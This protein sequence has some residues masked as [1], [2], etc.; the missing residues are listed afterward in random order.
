MIHICKG[1]IKYGFDKYILYID[2]REHEVLT[3]ST[4]GV[5]ASP[6]KNQESASCSFSSSVISRVN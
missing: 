4:D 3:W 5:T 2:T 6:P 1:L